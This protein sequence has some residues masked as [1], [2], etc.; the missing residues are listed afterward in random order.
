MRSL[1][2]E[3]GQQG[4][5]VKGLGRPELPTLLPLDDVEVFVHR[6][7]TV[8]PFNDL[9]ARLPPH[10]QFVPDGDQPF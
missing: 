5:I 9:G 8:K 2:R 4:R 7:A 1:W 10:A 3:Q 6:S